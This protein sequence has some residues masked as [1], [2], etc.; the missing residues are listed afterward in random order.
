IRHLRERHLPSTRSSGWLR[1]SCW[2]CSFTKARSARTTGFMTTWLS[3]FDKKIYTTNSV[4]S[5]KR[6]SSLT[7]QTDVHS[8]K[9]HAI[10]YICALLMQLPKSRTVSEMHTTKKTRATLYSRCVSDHNDRYPSKSHHQCRDVS[11]IRGV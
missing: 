6:F 5:L 7:Q 4:N 11:L 2:R 3:S 9:S 1:K 8:N 10:G